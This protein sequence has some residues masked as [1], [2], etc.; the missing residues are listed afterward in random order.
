MA[1]AGDVN[2][3]GLMDFLVGSIGLDNVQAGASNAGG[4]DLY[5]GFRTRKTALSPTLHG[6]RFTD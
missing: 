1:A 2:R 4:V 5:L 6:V 3:D